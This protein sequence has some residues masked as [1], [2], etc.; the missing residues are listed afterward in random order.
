MYKSDYKEFSKIDR[1]LED[2]LRLFNQVQTFSPH[3]NCSKNIIQSHK[4]HEIPKP[5]KLKVWITIAIF[6]TQNQKTD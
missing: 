6:I 2:L 3:I 1:G 5:I 4:L